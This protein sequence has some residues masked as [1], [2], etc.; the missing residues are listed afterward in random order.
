MVDFTLT[1]NPQ[2]VFN[3]QAEFVNCSMNNVSSQQVIECLQSTSVEEIL[4]SSTR[5]YVCLW[6]NIL[7]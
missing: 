2:E 6:I 4:N 7:N 3:Q 1:T 5:F